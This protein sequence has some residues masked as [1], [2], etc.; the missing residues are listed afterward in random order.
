M[1][2]SHAARVLEA[3]A[4]VTI[5]IDGSRSRLDALTPN[6]V[7]AV[8]ASRQRSGTWSYARRYFKLLESVNELEKLHKGLGPLAACEPLPAPRA[9]L[10]FVAD[11]QGP[12]PVS[13]NDW[14]VVP[15]VATA[16]PDTPVPESADDNLSAWLYHHALAY[17]NFCAQS[18]AWRMYLPIARAAIKAAVYLPILLAWLGLA[19]ALMFAL[20]VARHPEL[21]VSLLFSVLDMGPQ[22]VSWAG[23]QMLDQASSEIQSRI[24]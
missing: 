4:S 3:A 22:Y 1:S 11:T 12:A 21:L 15:Y 23:Q 18:W 14:A 5:R 20:Y 13:S 17:A 2:A 8:K 10:G 9:A 6:Q 24:R 16:R 7:E 19:Y